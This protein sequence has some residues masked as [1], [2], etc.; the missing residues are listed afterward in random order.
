MYNVDKNRVRLCSV[1]KGKSIFSV[2]YMTCTPHT[3]FTRMWLAQQSI[4]GELR[5]TSKS[6][7]LHNTSQNLET[8]PTLTPKKKPPPP[9]PGLL[10][11]RLNYWAQLFRRP[12]LFHA[13][14]TPEIHGSGPVST[15]RPHHDY[16]AHTTPRW[17]F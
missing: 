15:R 8:P 10:P 13:E 17:R 14:D 1:L 3:K 4:K 16:T 7:T 12:D 6:L 5:N 11:V 9:L 2:L